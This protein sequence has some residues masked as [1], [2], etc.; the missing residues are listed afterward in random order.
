MNNEI[1]QA[2]AEVK[3]AKAAK[4]FWADVKTYGGEGAALRALY[5]QNRI[6]AITMLAAVQTVSIF[7]RD[8]RVVVQ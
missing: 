3:T 7:K 6:E 5:C 2:V 8:G 4:M 1:Q